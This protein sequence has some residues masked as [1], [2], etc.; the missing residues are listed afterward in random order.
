MKTILQLLLILTTFVFLV[1]LVVVM[2]FQKNA[3]I[4]NSLV[5]LFF[6]VLSGLMIIWIFRKDKQRIKTEQENLLHEVERESDE[7]FRLRKYRLEVS[8]TRAIIVLL[9]IGTLGFISIWGVIAAPKLPIKIGAAGLLLFTLYGSLQTKKLLVNPI[10]EMDINY[11]RHYL[12]GDIPWNEVTQI[13]MRAFNVKGQTTYSL[14]LR[15][16]DEEK[17]RKRL[18]INLGQID[19]MGVLHLLLPTSK[20][21]ACI[22]GA[23]AEKFAAFA[24]APTIITKLE[25]LDKLSKDIEELSNAE[26]TSENQEKFLNALQLQLKNQE[27]LISILDQLDQ[28]KKEARQS[29]LK[30]LMQMI[31]GLMIV[32]IAIVFLVKK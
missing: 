1:L 4:G 6:L 13:F 25:E 7:A 24:K 8:L 27:N 9:T 16:L 31:F 26:S 11:L 2:H 28:R 15:V 30:G 17:Y 12:L 3:E 21:N 32:A 10:V 18:Y 29:L 14:C 23:T 22:V 5:A 19:K 20:K